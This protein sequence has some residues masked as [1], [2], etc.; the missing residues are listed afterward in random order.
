MTFQTLL[1]FIFAP[2]LGLLI[3]FRAFAV[4]AA[5]VCAVGLPVG[6]AALAQ[7][8]EKA[9]EWTV[10]CETDEWDDIPV[11]EA[12]ASHHLGYRCKGTEEQNAY[13]EGTDFGGLSSSEEIIYRKRNDEPVF[14]VKFQMRWDKEPAR[15]AIMLK[16]F[17][18]YTRRYWWWQGSV[19]PDWWGWEKFKMTPTTLP[20][21][22]P[23]LQ[24]KSQLRI[25][26]GGK[27]VLTFSLAGAREAIAEAKRGC[28]L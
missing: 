13:Y 26:I 24:T 3:R 7:S 8:E 10:R 27:K 18:P 25:R 1:M 21:P 16:E 5:L 2:V 20:N 15:E 22:I 12:V 4:V 9:P 6:G 17:L 19:G 28:G 14:L 23:L 11:C